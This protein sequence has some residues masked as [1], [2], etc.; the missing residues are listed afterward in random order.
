M[1]REQT[2]NRSVLNGVVLVIGLC[3]LSWALMSQMHL[4]A[5]KKEIAEKEM[6]FAMMQLQ[7]ELKI[8]TEALYFDFRLGGEINTLRLKG[9]RNYGVTRVLPYANLRSASGGI[10]MQNGMREFPIEDRTDSTDLQNSSPENYWLNHVGHPCVALAGQMTDGTGLGGYL[11]QHPEKFDKHI[12][13]MVVRLLDASHPWISC[14]ACDVLLAAGDRS[15]ELMEIVSILL[16]LE[17]SRSNA[18]RLVQRYGLNITPDPTVSNDPYLAQ[19]RNP[20]W[21]RVHALTSKLKEKHPM[22]IGTIMRDS[23]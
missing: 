1:S 3:L 6:R 4:R 17:S 10:T 13:P 22:A 19:S 11:K 7:H 16:S 18:Q 5:L 9:Y 12:R 2:G 8:P 23:D 14:D 21:K 15:D 20:E